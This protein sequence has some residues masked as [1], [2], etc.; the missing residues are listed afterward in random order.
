MVNLG[1]EIAQTKL[2]TDVASKNKYF[3][4]LYFWDSGRYLKYT[5]SNTSSGH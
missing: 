5:G 4:A 2:G 3:L 1:T